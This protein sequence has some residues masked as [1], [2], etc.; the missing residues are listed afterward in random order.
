MAA[1][2]E[3]RIFLPPGMPSAGGRDGLQDELFATRVDNQEG[4]RPARKDDLQHVT[5]GPVVDRPG[6]V[7][8]DA[9]VVSARRT[10]DGAVAR[11]Q[12]EASASSGKRKRIAGWPKRLLFVVIFFV[13]VRPGSQNLFFVG[14]GRHPYHSQETAVV[15][16]GSTQ[17]GIRTDV[18]DGQFLAA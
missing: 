13:G 7:V 9:P 15:P 2:A 4:F 1:P 16:A 14:H 5:F 12:R 8:G 18:H 3:K 11:K 10:Y 6:A 17:T